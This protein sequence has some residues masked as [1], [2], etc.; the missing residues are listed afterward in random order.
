M[1]L[2]FDDAGEVEQ[3]VATLRALQETGQG[4]QV[5]VVDEKLRTLAA[6]DPAEDLRVRTL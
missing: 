1:A 4:I 2:C 3:A 5:I 6:L